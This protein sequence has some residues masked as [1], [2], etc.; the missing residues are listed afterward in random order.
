MLFTNQWYVNG[1]TP[2]HHHFMP[3]FCGKIRKQSLHMLKFE[4]F[5]DKIGK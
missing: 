4:G 2:T 1:W 3:Q 5:R